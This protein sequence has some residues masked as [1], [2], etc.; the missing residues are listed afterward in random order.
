MVNKKQRIV[1]T[2]VRIS[3]FAETIRT[4]SLRRPTTLPIFQE[5]SSAVPKGT[6]A[7]RE[8]LRKGDCRS[9]NASTAFRQARQRD[10]TQPGKP[11]QEVTD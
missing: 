7:T 3:S 4:T 11:F 2:G 8:A 10:W 9:K 5:E 1:T 6:R